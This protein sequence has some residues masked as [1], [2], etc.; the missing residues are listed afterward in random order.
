MRECIASAPGT[1]GKAFS[2]AAS[3]PERSS[4]PICFDRS[5]INAEQTS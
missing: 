1:E 3:T 5:P 2:D 4:Q